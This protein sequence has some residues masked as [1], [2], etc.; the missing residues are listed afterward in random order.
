LLN[1]DNGCR[2][3][4]SVYV[5]CS[6]SAAPS[7]PVELLA[8]DQKAIR[9]GCNPVP[10]S[11]S[12]RLKT[13]SYFL[14]TTIRKSNGPTLAVRM[15]QLPSRSSSFCFVLYQSASKN[16]EFRRREEVLAFH[17]ET[18]ITTPSTVSPAGRTRRSPT[19]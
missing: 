1:L 12:L 19:L 5:I 4:C 10:T 9:P 16:I 18:A 6:E 3:K 15:L 2:I 11:S 14:E 17:Q 7:S 13:I 8:Y